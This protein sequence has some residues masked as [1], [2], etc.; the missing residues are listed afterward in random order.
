M[1]PIL[2]SAVYSNNIK[3]ICYGT[4]TNLVNIRVL[5]HR[6]KKLGGGKEIKVDALLNVEYDGKYLAPPSGY[7]IARE[8]A[9]GT[10][11][12]DTG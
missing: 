6:A 11:L 5:K 3:L 4:Y 12:R 7:C 8:R 2:F 10:E 9:S 1:C